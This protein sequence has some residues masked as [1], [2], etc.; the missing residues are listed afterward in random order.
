M[1]HL[2]PIDKAILKSLTGTDFKVS[3]LNEENHTAIISCSKRDLEY[4]ISYNQTLDHDDFDK[5]YVSSNI[6]DIEEIIDV[7]G[8]SF[9]RSIKESTMYDDILKALKSILDD[10]LTENLMN[11]AESRS[12]DFKIDAWHNRTL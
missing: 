8:E 1:N 12:E 3:E 6:V 4:R 10:H 7:D 9:Y 2:K 5:L 11:E